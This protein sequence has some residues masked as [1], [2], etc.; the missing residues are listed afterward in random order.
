MKT[1][2]RYAFQEIDS[3]N[4][5][6]RRTEKNSVIGQRMNSSQ[7]M[8]PER[9]SGISISVVKCEGCSL[10]YSNPQAIPFDIQDHYGIEPESYWED[11]Y[12]NSQSNYFSWQIGRAKKFINFH[13]GMT[14]LDIGAGIGKCMVALKN[15]GFI[16]YGVEPSKQFWE[17]A[18]ANLIVEEGHLKLAKI[19]EVQF[20]PE[21]FDF[22]TFGAVLEHL[23]DPAE[24]IEKAVYWLKPNGIIQIEVPSSN[25]LIPKLV[26]FF[27]RIRG[28]RFV[29]N[30]S[31]MHEPYHLHE[32]H[33][34]SFK[35]LGQ[36]LNFTIKEWKYSVCKVY[37]FP[38]FIHPLLDWFMRKTSQGMQL[39]IWLGKDGK[40]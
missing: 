29:T 25:W 19:E 39:T 5:C 23:Y 16:T 36:R 17:R 22:I 24:A 37:Y 3:C 40:K 27:Y 21:S 1:K 6:G 20:P 8:R 14:A 26:N 32:F 34:T 18:V 4:F 2:Y 35:R 12:F 33:L 11:D 30:L 9:K 31:P 28:T 10:I 13:D 38:T 15:A 7:G